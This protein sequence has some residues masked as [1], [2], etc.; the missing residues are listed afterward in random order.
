M[1]RM[2]DLATRLADMDAMGVD[3]QVISPSILHQCTYSLDPQEALRL[4]RIG[5]DH[6]AE[7]VAKKPDRLIGLGSVPLQDATLAAAEMERA[8]RDLGLKGIIDRLARQRDR[9]RRSAAAA[10]LGGG[11]SARRSD[12]HPS[13]RQ[14][15][16][17]A[18]PAQPAD[19]ARPAAGGSVRAV[20]A[21]LRRR[22][23]RVSAPQDRVRA[24]RRLHPLLHRPLRLDGTGAAPPRASRATSAP[25]C[26]RSTTRAWCST[27][28]CWS[29]SPRRSTP[30]HIMLGT[31]YPFGEWQPVAFVESA[32]EIPE[33]LRRDILGANAA[34]FLGR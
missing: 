10:V 28:M 4:E 8:V 33:A 16:P 21:D 17:A 19:L 11:R 1:A 30:S 32:K 34:R 23:G 14:P 20:L 12:L 27:R 3:I 25:I 13:G 18:A 29:A 26:A 6:V 2:T 22:H 31:D 7:T 5:N 9:A 24:W 15:G